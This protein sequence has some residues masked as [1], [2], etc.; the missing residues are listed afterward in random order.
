MSVQ[1]AQKKRITQNRQTAVRASSPT[2]GARTCNRLI[3]EGPDHTPSDGVESDNIIGCLNCVEH[4][5]YRQGR[6]LEANL[7]L[8][9]PNP[10]EF[11]VPDVV[12]RDLRKQAMTLP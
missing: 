7:R 6:R 11:Q 2:A 8:S 3:R 10:C 5:V 4:T 9:L 12:R 1:C